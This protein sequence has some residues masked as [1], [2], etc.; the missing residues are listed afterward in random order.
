[1]R[2]EAEADSVAGAAD[3]D[4]VLD[5][6]LADYLSRNTAAQVLRASLDRAGVGFLP[7]VDHITFRTLDVDRRAEEFLRL[8]YAYDETLEYQDWFAKI[9]RAPGYPAL[10]I[11]QAFPGDRGGSSIIPGWVAAFGDR[12]LHHVAVRVEDIEWAIQA[13][14]SQGVRFSGGIVGDKGGVLRQIFTAPEQLGG[15][16]FSVLELTERHR[17]FR[18]FSPPQAD[19]LMKST[20]KTWSMGV[21]EGNQ[22]AIEKVGKN[23]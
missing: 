23:R 8:G 17:G 10:F 16:P 9:Y 12:T 22:R 4:R 14:T 1:M 7:V 3:L 20:V 11:D 15:K 6:L 19:G 13:L 2:R 18:G 21:A 5:G